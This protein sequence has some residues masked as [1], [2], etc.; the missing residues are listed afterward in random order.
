MFSDAQK[1]YNFVTIKF[2]CFFSNVLYLDMKCVTSFL[3][4]VNEYTKYNDIPRIQ[5]LE[6]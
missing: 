1:H 3:D 4:T 5:Y 6:M 2:K